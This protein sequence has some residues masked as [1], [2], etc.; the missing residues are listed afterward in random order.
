MYKTFDP[1]MVSVVG[2]ITTRVLYPDS[3]LSMTL[4]LE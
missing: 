3:E 1:V 4:Y 2:S